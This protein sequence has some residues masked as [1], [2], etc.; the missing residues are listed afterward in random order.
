MI[1]KAETIIDDPGDAAD[2]LN[3]YS[4]IDKVLKRIPFIKTKQLITSII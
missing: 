3:N 1:K 4:G 2:L